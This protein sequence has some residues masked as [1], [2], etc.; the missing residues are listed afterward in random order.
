MQTIDGSA[1]LE[2]TLPVIDPNF[3]TRVE[4]ARRRMY[5]VEPSTY[6]DIHCANTNHQHAIKTYS[7]VGRRRMGGYTHTDKELLTARS[8][9]HYIIHVD[10]VIRSSKLLIRKDR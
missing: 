1:H 3:L 4:Q 7:A 2:H 9:E 8:R 6:H 10:R 5:G